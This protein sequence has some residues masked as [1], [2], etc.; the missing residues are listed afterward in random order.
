MPGSVAD[1]I[2]E[3]HRVVLRTGNELAA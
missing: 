1:R 2:P 3:K